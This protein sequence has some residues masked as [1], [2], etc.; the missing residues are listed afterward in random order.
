MA[1]EL[2]PEISPGTRQKMDR[3]KR[4]DEERIAERSRRRRSLVRKF[5]R[6]APSKVRTAEK[7]RP[8]KSPSLETPRSVTSRR[9]ASGRRRPGW[10]SRS[11][12]VRSPRR[13]RSPR[14]K[15]GGRLSV[16]GSRGQRTLPTARR[17]DAAEMHKSFL[18]SMSEVTSP[19]TKAGALYNAVASI[20]LM[21]EER[22]GGAA[23]LLKKHARVLLTAI[24]KRPMTSSI[25]STASL[26]SFVA[27]LYRHAPRLT[28]E[29]ASQHVPRVESAMS[30]QL[31]LDRLN[32]ADVT[33]FEKLYKVLKNKQMEQAA[34][35]VKVMR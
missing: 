3:E 8:I 32:R 25:K 9:S 24:L 22:R 28:V 33:S 31:H 1:G 34:A 29:V 11:G 23:K 13:T 12:H 27:F 21:A 20:I 7:R 5:D 30:R 17:N 26:V 35:K 6:S 10:R 18:K 14:R 19:D 15:S 2:V 4:R 16:R